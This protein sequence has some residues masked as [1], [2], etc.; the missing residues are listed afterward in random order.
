MP[1]LRTPHNC[2][3]FVPF[4]FLSSSDTPKTPS[5]GVTPLQPPDVM[6]GETEAAEFAPRHRA[7]L[8]PKARP[9]GLLLQASFQRGKSKQWLWLL[10]LEYVRGRHESDCQP[11]LPC[12]FLPAPTPDTHTPCAHS[13]PP[14]GAVW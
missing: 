10:V 9:R 11:L 12:P 6:E 4:L 1:I 13:A 8:G 7:G 14:R 5:A 2:P 3:S